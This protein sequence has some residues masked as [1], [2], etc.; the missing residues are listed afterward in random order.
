MSGRLLEGKVAIVTGAGS[1]I[2][3]G[4]AMAMAL[5]AEGARVAMCDVDEAS[6]TQ[7]AADVNHAAGSGAALPIVTDVGNPDHAERA[8]SR[9]IAELGGLHIL[10]NNA[11]IQP[12]FGQF[13][14]LPPDQW[15]RTIATNMTGPF[16]MAHAAVGHLR[17]QGWGRIVGVTT[18]FDTMLR[19]APYGPAK[20]GHEALIAVMARELAGSGVSANVLTPGRSV[21]TN[22]V[23]PGPDR[24]FERLQPEVMQAPAVWLASTA[25]DGFNGQR[26]V[27]QD[28]DQ[29]LPIEQRLGK[30]SAPAGWPAL[31]RPGLD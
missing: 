26:I 30:A 31:G 2:G 21:Q 23:P 28:W 10:I 3:L 15:A 11:G 1:T 4:R 6:L 18:S 17:E 14:N 24:R 13:W 7:S 25:S 22:M 12:R 8:I 19:I 16:L 29:S 20:A 27:A 5:A 9:A